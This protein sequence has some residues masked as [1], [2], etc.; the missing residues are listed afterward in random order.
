MH[1]ARQLLVY[2]IAYGRWLGYLRTVTYLLLTSSATSHH[3]YTHLCRP[4]DPIHEYEKDGS[5]RRNCLWKARRRPRLSWLRRS[6]LFSF[7]LRQRN[8]IYYYKTLHSSLVSIELPI[9]R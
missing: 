8:L 4:Q 3:Y 9:Q 6:L 5:Y 1:I 7:G 2:P